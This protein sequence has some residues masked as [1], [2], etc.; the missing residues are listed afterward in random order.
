[1]S[2]NVPPVTNKQENLETE[3]DKS[4]RLPTEKVASTC[5]PYRKEE[6]SLPSKCQPLTGYSRIGHTLFKNSFI[7]TQTGGKPLFFSFKD[8]SNNQSS[9]R[10]SP[11]VGVSC[12]NFL[13]M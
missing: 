12:N 3:R 6:G 5:F 2:I 11:T 8:Q 7:G 4:Y 1:M 10:M 9:L 13:K